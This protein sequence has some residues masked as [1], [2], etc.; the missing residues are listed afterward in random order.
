MPDQ[1]DDLATKLRALGAPGIHGYDT[2]AGQAIYLAHQIM[3]VA[4]K[5]RG[6]V[7]AEV[8][9]LIA[10]RVDPIDA[11]RRTIMAALSEAADAEMCLNLFGLSSRTGLPRETLRGIMADLRAEGLATHHKGLWSE[12]GA[13]AGAGYSIT[14]PGREQLRNWA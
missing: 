13:P 1:L 9:R 6:E 3:A 4:R 8:D 2:P 14:D 11:L 10:E 12:D 5:T 7:Q